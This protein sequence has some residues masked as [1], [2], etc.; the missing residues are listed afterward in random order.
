MDKELISHITDRIVRTFNPVRI[1][2]FGSAARSE[3]DEQSDL[4][5]FIG[6]ETDL[7]P[8]ER[9]VQ[10]S[11]IFGLRRWSLDLIVYTP[12]EVRQHRGIPGTMLSRIEAEGVALYERS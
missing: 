7:K 3:D 8:P 10:V 1:V 9:S 2:L 6:M 5:L 12:E 11:S 4:D